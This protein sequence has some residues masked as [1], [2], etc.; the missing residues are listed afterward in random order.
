MREGIFKP[1]GP[2]H[3]QVLDHQPRDTVCTVFLDKL[4]LCCA[5]RHCQKRS[6][7]S[8]TANYESGAATSS[9]RSRTA[10]AD[11]SHSSKDRRLATGV[12]GASSSAKGSVVES[13]VE[14]DVRMELEQGKHAVVKYRVNSSAKMQSVINKVGVLYC[15]HVLIFKARAFCFFAVC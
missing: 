6:S 3:T 12:T 11:V 2:Q 8:Q 7:R 13:K 14:M 5:R 9:G 4:T 10:G 15:Q 1:T